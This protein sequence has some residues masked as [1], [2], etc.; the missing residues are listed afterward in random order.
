MSLTNVIAGPIISAILFLLKIY[1]WI[2]IIAIFL[3]WVRPDPYNPIVRFLNSIT[4]PVFYK[5]RQLL[6]FLRIGRID[7]S[8]IAVFIFI[9]ILQ[10]LLVYI[11]RNMGIIIR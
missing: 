1:S 4:G 8:P 9:R 7:L 10:G 11:A 3:S 5:V 6:P 2:L